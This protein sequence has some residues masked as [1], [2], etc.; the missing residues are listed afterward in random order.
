MLRSCLGVT[1]AVALVAQFACAPA[2]P[3]DS[4]EG[5]T[6]AYVPPRT[7]DGEPDL[8][9]VWQVLNS[10]DASI[11]DHSA[12]SDGPAGHGVVEGNEIPYQDWAV[13][14]Q[15]ENY[16]NREERDPVRQCFLPG[17]PRATY[18]PLPFQII[19]AEGHVLLLYEFVHA[20]R[21]V[22]TNDT[23]HLQDIDSW[24]GDSRGHWEGDT[25]VVDVT[26][27]NG[28]TWLDRVG[29]FHSEALHVVERYTPVGP[30]HMEYEATIEDPNV[31]TRPWTMSMMLY[32]RKE[33]NAQVFD[34]Q[35]YAFDHGEEG[36]TVPLFR[37]STLE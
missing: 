22:Y 14:Q 21:R 11:L 9:G 31:Y 28:L 8:Q 26:N 13:T 5:E 29:N 1:C 32:R 27:F 18:I 24:M 16:A 25:L 12:G 19:Q 17:V 37:Y 4:S 6:Q 30:D 36:L 23:P 2:P 7:L 10:A 34:Y 3:S 15:E 33:P 20:Q 35:C